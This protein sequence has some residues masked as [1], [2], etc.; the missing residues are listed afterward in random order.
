MYGEKKT[1]REDIRDM[2]SQSPMIFAG[3]VVGVA[4]SLSKVLYA[5][6]IHKK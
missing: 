5:I 6:L 3:M 4:S 1:F 2:W